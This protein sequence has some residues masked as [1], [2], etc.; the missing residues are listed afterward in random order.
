M[1]ENLIKYRFTLKSL[2]KI[3]MIQLLVVFISIPKISIL[4]R[5]INRTLLVPS[6]NK[7]SQS[8]P[9]SESESEWYLQIDSLLKVQR[10]SNIITDSTDEVKI[11]LQSD[12]K[13]DSESE[14]ERY[15]Q[16]DSLLKV[17]RESN[18][19]TGSESE[20]ESG[21]NLQID[22]LLKVQRESNIIT[23][24]TDEVKITLQSD[25]ESESVYDSERFLKK[26]SNSTDNNKHALRL[27]IF[28][29]Y[30][31]E[32]HKD[33]ENKGLEIEN[34]Y[35]VHQA[36]RDSST[37]TEFYHRIVHMT[38]IKIDTAYE[39][40]YILLIRQLLT[41]YGSFSCQE[42]Y[43]SY[44]KSILRFQNEISRN[45]CP[46]FIHDLDFIMHIRPPNFNHKEEANLLHLKLDIPRK[47]HRDSLAKLNENRKSLL[48]INTFLL[49]HITDTDISEDFIILKV[50]DNILYWLRLAGLGNKQDISETDVYNIN[51]QIKSIIAGIRYLKYTNKLHNKFLINLTKDQSNLPEC[52]LEYKILALLPNTK[53]LL[54]TNTKSLLPTIKMDD[55]LL[56]RK[57]AIDV[58]KL[59]S[60]DR[61]IR[62]LI[63]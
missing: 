57:Q 31:K 37:I 61:S 45:C 13:S 44:Q 52:S 15:L 6:N 34:K 28:I 32:I 43:S 12:F 59:T 25:F 5:K 2:L 41:L 26:T 58:M 7:K 10:E 35:K 23:D 49:H 14:S 21:S 53:S 51:T 55:L 24:S 29:D 18:I 47:S 4:Y 19:I 50:L 1:A 38:D 22:S 27:R 39:Y 54:T 36:L 42:I 46:L 33:I 11:T 62:S 30:I 9:E 48:E 8:P 56:F 3:I 16:I 20:S 63:Y 60:L 40:Y 17:Q